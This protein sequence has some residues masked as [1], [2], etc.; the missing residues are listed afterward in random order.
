[1]STNVESPNFSVIVHKNQLNLTGLVHVMQSSGPLPQ[2][3][4]DRL[5]SMQDILNKHGQTSVDQSFATGAIFLI[6]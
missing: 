5:V 6:W 1:M 3:H 2:V 4:C